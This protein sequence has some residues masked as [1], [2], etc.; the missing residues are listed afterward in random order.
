MIH[1]EFLR[2]VFH[3]P[4]R[5]RENAVEAGNFHVRQLNFRSVCDIKNTVRLQPVP[6]AEYGGGIFLYPKCAGTVMS[7]HNIVEQKPGNSAAGI[8]GNQR[9]FGN[10]SADIPELNV[11]YPFRGGIVL[12][13][14]GTGKDH[15]CPFRLHPQIAEQNVFDLDTFT[16]IGKIVGDNADRGPRLMKYD[17]AYHAVTDNSV[18]DSD[19]DR[20][21]AGMENAVRYR[22]ML[23]R[24]LVLQR[25]GIPAERDAVVAGINDAVA[26]R[27]APAAVDVDAVTVRGALVVVNSEPFHENILAPVQKTGPVGSVVKL[28]SS[29][30]MLRDSQKYSICPGRQE[31]MLKSRFPGVQSL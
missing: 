6:F 27:D 24:A 4:G 14:G 29:R 12:C 1:P 2:T 21:A 25:C 9:R 11:P 3:N 28:T 23:A 30:W 7:E 13:A 31:V 17:I 5:I 15:E 8:S 20:V 22:N 18:S 26:H 16:F 19:P 10:G